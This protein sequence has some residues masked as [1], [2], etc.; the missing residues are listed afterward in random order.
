MSS[1][2]IGDSQ[3]FYVMQFIN[4][5]PV[6]SLASRMSFNRDHCTQS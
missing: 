5:K 6:P 2:G 4:L 1:P 3:G